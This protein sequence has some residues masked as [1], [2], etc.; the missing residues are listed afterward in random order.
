MISTAVNKFFGKHIIL[1][2][3]QGEHLV[4]MFDQDKHTKY[5]VFNNEVCTRVSFPVIFSV[6]YSS[7]YAEIV[8]TTDDDINEWIMKH[9]K[10]MFF[11][12]SMNFNTYL[13]EVK[14]AAYLNDIDLT[15]YKVKFST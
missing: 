8:Y 14:V 6:D 11:T 2:S 5:K 4:E 15:F 9:G 3:P 7:S 10:N 1:K 13:P 12:F